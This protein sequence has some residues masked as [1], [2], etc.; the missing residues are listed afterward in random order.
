M[1]IFDLFKGGLNSEKQHLSETD[2]VRNIIQSLDAMEPQR[3]KF[4]AAFAF[5]LSRAARADLFISP[6]ETQKM[7][8]IIM[9]LGDLPEHQAV[10]VIQLAKTQNIL[11]GATENYLVAREFNSIASHQEKMRLLDCIYAVAAADSSISAIEEN[12]ISQIAEELRIEH[13]DLISVRSK[14]RNQL[15]VL[16][17]STAV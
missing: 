2:T 14:Y 8:Q 15:A 13:P 16:K 7:E 17:N 6:E 4:I 10:M 3:A 5:L 1:N 12:E 11:F 9:Q